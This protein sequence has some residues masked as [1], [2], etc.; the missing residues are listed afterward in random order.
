MPMR[1]EETSERP[2]PDDCPSD[3]QH[4]LAILADLDLR[5]AIQRDQLESWSGPRQVKTRLLADLDRCHR[6]NRERL[7]ACLDRHRPGAEDSGS[8]LAGAATG[9]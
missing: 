6:S 4:I 3:L 1:A 2:D 8:A 9:L 7:A 5:H